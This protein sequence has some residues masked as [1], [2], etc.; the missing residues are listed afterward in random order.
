M[1]LPNERRR[2]NYHII[3]YRDS[4]GQWQW[5]MMD[6]RN[7][8]IVGASHEGFVAAED[9]DHNLFINTGWSID[10]VGPDIEVA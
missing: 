6:R 4:S 1:S 8:E 7:S 3:R 5:S 9:C 2:E 10:E